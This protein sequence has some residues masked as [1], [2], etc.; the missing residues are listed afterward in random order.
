[1]DWAQ[2]ENITWLIFLPIFIGLAIYVY[3]WRKRTREK[4]A[5]SA[6]LPKLFPTDSKSDYVVKTIIIAMGFLLGVLALMDPLFGEE[7]V[8]IKREGVDIIYAL[9]LSNSMNAEDVVPSRIERAKKIISESIG[10]LGGDRVGLI[11]FAADAYSISPL[12]NDY[13]AI[14]SYI[15]TANPE[16]ISQQGTSY[17]AVIAKAAE[18]FENAPTTGKLLVILSDGEDNE[19]SV[20][21]AIDL[22][23]DKNIHIVTMGI[24]TKSGGPIPVREGQFES[25]KLDRNGETVISKLIESSML[26]LAQST[27]GVYIRVNQTGESLDQLHRFLNTLDREVQDMAMRKDKKHIYQFVLIFALLFIF[28]D[29]LT[30]DHK[31][32][33]NKK[34]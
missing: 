6:L 8:K 5:D 23:K 14:Q 34:Q 25:F 33:N 24:G 31:L 21:K 13:G 7:E 1:M 26:S 32:F 29:T 16:L 19:N 11:V 22:A 20:S 2:P 18:M 9:D 17:S 30:T 28:I 27:S 3:N 15:T 4:F 12:T 10:R